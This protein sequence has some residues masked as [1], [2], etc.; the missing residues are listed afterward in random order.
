MNKYDTVNDNMI[1]Y[2]DAYNDLD[3]TF[4]G[5]E[6]NHVSRSSNEEA[7]V[8]VNIGSKCLPVPPG[9]FWEE[10]SERSIKTKKKN[11][12][13]KQ[14]GKKPQKDSGSAST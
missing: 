2:R 7:K 3:G 4:D 10:I 13:Q 14:K 8:L 5:C 12:P 6:V 1:A 11:S 9:V